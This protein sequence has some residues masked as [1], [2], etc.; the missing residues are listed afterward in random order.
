MSE[1]ILSRTTA[2]L[3]AN[4][5][6]YLNASH[7]CLGMLV[8][9]C[10]VQYYKQQLNSK[11]S[12][13]LDGYFDTISSYLKARFI[14]VMT[15]H[16]DSL[17]QAIPS[18]LGPIDDY[19]RPHY[20]TRRYAEFLA[21]LLILKSNHSD[22]LKQ[23]DMDALMKNLRVEIISLLER[24]A[25]TCAKEGKLLFLINN[26][27]LINALV[28]E[29]N[30]ASADTEHLEKL[31]DTEAEKYGEGQ[32]IKYF[33]KLL[34][35]VRAHSVKDKAGKVTPTQPTCEPK[36]VEEILRSFTENNYWKTSIENIHQT[37][38]ENFPD[39]LNGRTIFMKLLTSLF[40]HYSLL[41][42]IITQYFKDLR[43]SKYYIPISDLRYKI[44][45]LTPAD[46]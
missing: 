9:Q 3:T 26:Y 35:F 18:S 8:I 46:D 20:V 1:Q 31:L 10:F 33:S 25:A 41:S 30:V 27:A 4:L 2:L 39:F 7:D 19:R 40:F 37:I 21:S 28:K 44:K 14:Q 13:S 29:H 34:T 24:M 23:F 17:K 6:K 16:V 43:S 22:V 32:L 5:Q 12:R 42:D 36:S 45:E 15:L 38:M 11:S